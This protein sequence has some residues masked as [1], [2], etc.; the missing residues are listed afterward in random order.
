[1]SWAWEVAAA[2]SCVDSVRGGR[3]FLARISFNKVSTIFE[4]LA[5][6]GLIDKAVRGITRATNKIKTVNLMFWGR[7]S[8]GKMKFDLY[9]RHGIVVAIFKHISC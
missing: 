3:L 6:A 4:S 2:L 5:K 1:M 7:L 8:L 9:Q